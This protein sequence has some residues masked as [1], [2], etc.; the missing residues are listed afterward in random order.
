M[1][2]IQL[3]MM[4]TVKLL[5]RN[6]KNSVDELKVRDTSCPKGKKVEDIQYI[7][8]QVQDSSLAKVLVKFKFIEIIQKLF[9]HKIRILPAGFSACGGSFLRHLSSP[10]RSDIVALLQKEKLNL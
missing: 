8:E 2:K 6:H 9:L 5:K 3:I 4:K 10:L 7:L 1:L